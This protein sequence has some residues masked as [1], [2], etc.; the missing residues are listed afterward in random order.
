MRGPDLAMHTPLLRR[1]LLAASAAAAIALPL[2]GRANEE[3]IVVGQIGPFSGTALPDAQNLRDGIQAAFAQTNAAGG[4]NGRPLRLL[5]LDDGNTV[6]G[7]LRQFA[8]AM[9]RR[10]VALL[11]PVGS[12]P[13]A[14]MLDDKLLDQGDVVVLN[15]LSGAESLRAPGH[16]RLFHIHAGERQQIE[17]LLLHA[18]GQRIGHLA[19][20][21]L[22][23]HTGRSSLAVAHSV[24]QT[25]GLRLAAFSIAMESAQL[26]ASAE[27]AAA[28]QLQG[29]L[30]LGGSHFAADC[31]PA[32]RQANPDQWLYAM[33]PVP[34][35][36][37]QRNGQGRDRRI[38]LAQVCPAPNGNDLVLQRAFQRAMQD[39][40]MGGPYNALQC[41]GYISARVLVEG[42]RGSQDLRS[43]ALSRALRTMGPCDLGGYH[44][45]FARDNVGSSLVHINEPE[46]T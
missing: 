44:I 5:T 16:P 21:H 39:S 29:V 35:L 40:G 41:E 38:V 10:P 9:Q 25:L 6:E 7:F 20:L 43:A 1:S 8:Q 30:V 32:L 33:G 36:P 14:R 13:I 15:A 37:P 12:Q 26:Q 31:M 2:P 19:V 3:D 17:R 22:E 18:K 34:P 11:G 45:H 23:T 24:A 46:T 27:R 42:L 28:S 4:V